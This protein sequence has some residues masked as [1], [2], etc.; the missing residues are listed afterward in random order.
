MGV[1]IFVVINGIQQFHAELMSN[2][3]WDGAAQG[4]LNWL[5]IAVLVNAVESQRYQ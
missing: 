4:N 3:R 5:E 2:G 1:A